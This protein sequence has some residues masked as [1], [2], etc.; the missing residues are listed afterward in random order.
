MVS[1]VEAKVLRVVVGT[2][3][4]GGIGALIGA[5][6]QTSVVEDALR[7][8]NGRRMSASVRLGLEGG[9]FKGQW[10]ASYLASSPKA[11]SVSSSSHLC[12]LNEGPEVST[13]PY[14]TAMRY[15]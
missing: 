3:V 12:G 6:M 5:A 9:G 14:Y 1:D 15:H 4:L 13:G 7:Q 2:P 10:K 11:E 8:G